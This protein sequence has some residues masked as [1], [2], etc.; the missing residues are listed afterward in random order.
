MPLV[1]SYLLA[2]LL[3]IA[4]ELIVVLGFGFRQKTEIIAIIFINIFTNPALNYLLLVNNYFSLFKSN[5]LLTLFLEFLVTFVEWKLLIYAFQKKPSKLFKL[6]FA[7]NLFS[8]AAG[9]LIFSTRTILLS[10]GSLII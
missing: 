6:S 9:V 5:L 10:P 8:Y 3:T 1:N 2:L 7:M 4:V